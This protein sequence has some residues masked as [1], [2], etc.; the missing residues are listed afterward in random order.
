[1]IQHILVFEFITGG[2]FSQQA[3]P[4]S[5]AKEGLLMLKALIYELDLVSNVRITVMLD[6]RIEGVKLPDNC[7]IIEFQ[8]SKTFMAYC[9]N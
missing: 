2:G 4:D 9:Q 7:K 1:L 5:L 3:L 6:W 8:V